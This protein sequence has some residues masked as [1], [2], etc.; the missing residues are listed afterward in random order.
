[1]F[2]GEGFQA[3]RNYKIDCIKVFAVFSVVAVHFL[4]NSGFYDV[5]VNTGLRAVY[6]IFRLIFITA[7]PLFMMTTGYLMGQKTVS[8]QYLKKLIPV[9]LIYVA[10]SL[11]DWIGQAVILHVNVTF[12]DAARGLLDYSTDS[13]SWYVEMY[14]GLY[15]LIPILNA[16]WLGVMDKKYHAYIVVVSIILFFL[17]SLFN[18][19]EKTLPDWWTAA[20]PVGYYYIGLYIK[21]YF[22]DIKKIK[23]KNLVISNFILLLTLSVITLRDN[24]NHIFAWHDANDYMGYEVFVM[25][26]IIFINFLRLPDRTLQVK[27]SSVL[28]TISNMTLTIYLF[29]D[30]S[31]SIVYHYFKLNVPHVEER[32]MFGPLV[33]IT[34]FLLATVCAFM[35]EKSIFYLTA[36]GQH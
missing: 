20:Y 22:E 24:F 32:L 21:T 3:M 16:A 8:A 36:K 23:I 6:T 9:V 30:F 1:M 14:V 19:F 17:P 13:Y 15:L 10:V 29:S 25:S 27:K 26:I 28:K 18:V 31:D 4:L 12:V 33:I 11:I 35:L 7:V 5:T 34:S 2:S